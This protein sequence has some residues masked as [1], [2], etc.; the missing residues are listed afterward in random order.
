M[1]TL[2]RARH[3]NSSASTPIRKVITPCPITIV[4]FT[5]VM[6]LNNIIGLLRRWTM[7]FVSRLL[8]KISNP[9]EFSVGA[10]NHRHAHRRS[11]PVVSSQ[12]HRNGQKPLVVFSHA[13]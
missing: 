8:S 5:S 12:A 11:Q 4:L 13:H 7:D 6:S 9:V 3:L 2:Q 1:N 10:Q